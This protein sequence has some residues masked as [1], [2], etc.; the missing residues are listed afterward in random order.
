MKPV[1]TAACLLVLMV[2]SG[3]G[4]AMAQDDLQP[5]PP[6]QIFDNLYY[7][8]LE[9]VSAFV[10]R[11]SDGLILIDSLYPESAAY[12][13]SALE[14]LG[15]DPMDIRYVIV[16]HAHIDH[17]GSA[18]EIQRLT[19]ARVGMA[20][21]DWNAYAEGGYIS[22][23]GE[24][25]VFPPM[26]RD[27]VIDDGDRLTLGDTTIELYTTP[28]HT[29]GVVSLAFTVRDGNDS[30]NAFVFG[31]L[32]LN[33]VNGVRETEQYIDSVRRVMAMPDLEV[34]LTNHPGG[35]QIFA[36]R[37]RLASRRPGEPHPFVDPEGFGQYL[38]TLL[39]NA[40]KQLERERGGGRP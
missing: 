7:V 38:Q 17:A 37:D 6:F 4:L 25:R 5:V 14:D 12:I 10:L 11:T 34:N 27:L 1:F 20:E 21:A 36:R 9:S 31:G 40:Q 35:G 26:E 39:T 24:T 2:A 23:R 19:G 3:S 33:T 16:T 29:P 8:G 30:Y 18:G 15:L 22:S 32:G 13:L 28:G